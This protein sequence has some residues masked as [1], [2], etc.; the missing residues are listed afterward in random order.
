LCR[1][2]YRA[3]ALEF[4]REGAEVVVNDI[5]EGGRLVAE[6]IEKL[7]VKGVFVKSDVSKEQ[8]VENMFRRAVDIFSRVDILVNNAGVVRDALIHK[9]SLED[10]EAVMETN[11]KGSKIHGEA[12]VRKD[13]Q[14]IIGYWANGQYWP[15]KLCSI[16]S[17]NHRLDKGFSP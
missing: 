15:V 3:V 13:N 10:W 4:A 17:R 5:L 1:A 11:L 2:G 16:K 12:R 6:E 8:E 9:I 7:G 14:H